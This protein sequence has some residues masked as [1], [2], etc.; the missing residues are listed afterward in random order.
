MHTD[1]G[2]LQ[3][4]VGSNLF[5]FENLEIMCHQDVGVQ[6]GQNV[7]DSIDI[8][9]DR[10]Q[11]KITTDIHEIQDKWYTLHRFHSDWPRFVCFHKQ[12]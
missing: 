9:Y 7:T 3:R 11:I 6:H 1:K 5:V 10:C 4:P 8:A 2:G 12:K